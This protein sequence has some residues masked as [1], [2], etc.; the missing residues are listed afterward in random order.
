MGDNTHT[1]VLLLAL[2]RTLYLT[3]V[4]YQVRQAVVNTAQHRIQDDPFLETLFYITLLVDVV[5]A[6][7]V[8]PLRVRSFVCF[9]L[10]TL[11]H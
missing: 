8:M 6:L 2:R 5:I 10:L 4:E 11:T 3:A 1:H 7:S 9:L